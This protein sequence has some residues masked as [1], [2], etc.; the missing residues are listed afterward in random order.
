MET[1]EKFNTLMEKALEPETAFEEQE[2][3]RKQALELIEIDLKEKLE[4]NLITQTEYDE[5]LGLLT[6]LIRSSDLL[7]DTAQDLEE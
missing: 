5:R 6:S 4:N 3:L 1:M 7:S 2:S